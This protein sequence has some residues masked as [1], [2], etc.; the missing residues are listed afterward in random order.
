VRRDGGF[1]L[2]ELMVATALFACA[3]VAIALAL[4]SSYR[5]DLH[6]QNWTI[7]YRA[8]QKVMETWLS[9]DYQDLI[10]AENAAPASGIVEDF[11]V[12]S[13]PSA[14]GH[15]MIEDIGVAWGG[16]AQSAF[17]MTAFVDDQVRQIDVRIVTARC[18]F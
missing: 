17:R 11:V 13:S 6:A 5:T 18:R 2:L 8:A 9:K 4:Q 1:T 3:A 16:V 7:A 10:D 12:K 15:V 14:Q